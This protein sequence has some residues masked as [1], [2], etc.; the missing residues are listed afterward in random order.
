[1]DY[2]PV[3]GSERLRIVTVWRFQ[4]EFHAEAAA[5]LTGL[6]MEVYRDRSGRWSVSPKEEI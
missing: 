4:A 6:P 3:Q 1:M 5:E 2:Q